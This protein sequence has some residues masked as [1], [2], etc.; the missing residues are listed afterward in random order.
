MAGALR[1]T[2]PV[3]EVEVISETL[4]MGETMMLGLRL[5]EG[6]SGEGFKARFGRTP[7]SVFGT[8]LDELKGLGLLEEEGGTWRLTGRGRLLGNEVFQRF[9]SVGDRGVGGGIGG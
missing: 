5:T 9:V 2:G 1:E 8:D 6:V 7:G 3:S 4:E